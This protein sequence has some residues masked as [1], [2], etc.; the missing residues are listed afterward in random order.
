[1]LGGVNSL[2]Q[3]IQEAPGIG[4]L[5]EP[6]RAYEPGKG[7]LIEW[8]EG[9]VTEDEYFWLADPSVP[10]GEWPVLARTSPTD[11]WH[12]FSMTTSEFIHRVLADELAPFSIV[13]KLDRPYFELY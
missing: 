11:E 12:W 5:Y 6:C 1:M 3:E 4:S 7:G 13:G 8:G 2:L 10:A 9:V